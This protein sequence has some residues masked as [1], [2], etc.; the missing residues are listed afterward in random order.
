[1]ASFFSVE[2]ADAGVREQAFRVVL[3]NGMALPLV[4]ARDGG[5]LIPG[6]PFGPAT[7]E[8]SEVK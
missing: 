6:L 2:R 3:P 1:M 5:L 8:L 4:S 7:L